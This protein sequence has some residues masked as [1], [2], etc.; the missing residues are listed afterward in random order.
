MLSSQA[1][2]LS[3]G[4]TLAYIY[5][6]VDYGVWRSGSD[7]S[8]MVN[9][10]GNVIFFAASLAV[11][12]LAAA[13]P[14]P[15]GKAVESRA[16][17]PAVAFLG[18]LGAG[19]LIT[20]GPML[21]PSALPASFHNAFFIIGFVF[22]GLACGLTTLRCAKRYCEIGSSKVLFY[23]L[24][25]EIVVFVVFTVV[26]AYENFTFT[27]QGPS[28]SGAAALCTLPLLS[29]LASSCPAENEHED[30][31]G[32]D[33]GESVPYERTSIAL[34]ELVGMRTDEE[35]SE[36]PL[37]ATWRLFVAVFVFT[38]TASIVRNC[39]AAE[40]LTAS[41]QAIAQLTILMR[42]CIALV[43]IVGCLT[44]LKRVPI[45][46]LLLG[47]TAGI[48]LGLALISLVGSPSAAL[49]I[50]TSAFF[51]IFDVFI[52]CLLAFIVRSKGFDPIF[53]FGVGRGITCAGMLFAYVLIVNGFGSL[54]F[55]ESKWVGACLTIIVLAC[56]VL[57]LNESKVSEILKATDSDEIDLRRVFES[58][59]ITA[60]TAPPKVQNWKEA[61]K[62]VGERAQLSARE[63]EILQQLASNRLPK[64]TAEY[65]HIS[66][67]TV[68]THTRNIYAKLAVHSRE[69]LIALVKDEYDQIGK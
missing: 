62:A 17:Y 55:A 33:K 41:Y 38:A 52:W 6:L 19:L 14:K 32:R 40:Q 42:A 3:L 63:Q 49:C 26:A 60:D 11:F 44:M 67:S 31:T 8:S 61:C 21:Y 13:A 9:A 45:E 15:V 37:P 58:A 43:V 25:S 12:V 59:G 1:R 57:V 39:Y 35:P 10:H 50:I 30:R 29:C 69:E 64:D 51:F 28:I 20:S 7:P 24:T 53:L 22:C 27:E 46:K 56:T 18:I 16:I 34:R 48:A 54:L 66:V 68:R 5:L 2:Y 4:L 47:T 23:T 65:L 36:Q